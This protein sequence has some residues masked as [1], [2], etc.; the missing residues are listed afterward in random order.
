M[1]VI[2]PAIIQTSKRSPAEP[3][4][5]AISELTIKIP[6]PIIE[7]ITIIVESNN[8]SSCLKEDDDPLIFIFVGAIALSISYKNVL[9]LLKLSKYSIIVYSY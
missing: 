6:E 3:T 9:Y 5:R 7:P 2:T 1:R 4:E 8:P